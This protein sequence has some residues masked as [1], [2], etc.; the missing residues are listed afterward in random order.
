MKKIK[1]IIIAF[2]IFFI[3]GCFNYKE[4][5]QLALESAIGID[6][7]ENGYLFTVQVMNTKKGNSNS[8]ADSISPQFIIFEAEG[9]TIQEATNNIALDSPKMLY[10]EHLQ[11]LIIGEEL[12]KN[13]IKGIMDLSFRKTDSRKQ[14]LVAV[15]KNNTANNILKTL[16][17]LETI[18]AKNI[19]ETIENNEKDFGSNER[20]TFEKMLDYY[21]NSKIDIS[22]PAVITSNNQDQK[23]TIKNIEQADTETRVM[24]DGMV[25]FKDDK[26]VNYLTSEE[27]IALNY[28]K[29]NISEV[30]ITTECEENK[31]F[32]LKIF[33]SNSQINI[34]NNTLEIKITNLAKLIEINCDVNLENQ[35]EINNLEI[36]ANDYIKNMVT[37]TFQK[38]KKDN[39]DAVGTEDIF[40][41][42]NLKK[43][44]KIKNK[45][46]EYY[47]NLKIKV[48]VKTTIKDKGNILKVI[49]R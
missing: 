4:L 21:L 9:K 3:T 7:T 34:L 44:N 19:Y 12:A 11:L 40:Y 42:Y 31:Y 16:T 33:D 38:L 43:Y 6:K 41:K 35:H 24:L 23:D 2:L 46:S 18:N 32:G 47:K 17:P 26:M 25:Y 39:S 8:Q 15:A 27:S 22:L 10:R 36:K 30:A 45:W 20:V 29:D 13:G 1:I 37:N 5:N 49:R 28:L 14:F 48:D